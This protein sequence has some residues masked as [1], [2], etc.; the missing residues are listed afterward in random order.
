MSPALVLP[1]PSDR[2]LTAR[3]PDT[4]GGEE[5]SVRHR[6]GQFVRMPGS[7]AI[8]GSPAEIARQAVEMGLLEVDAFDR[9]LVF[10]GLDDTSVLPPRS[11]PF[12]PDDAARVLG[13]LLNKPLTLGNFPR[14][15]AAGHLLREVLQDGEVPRE[16][17]LRRVARFDGVAVLR[18]DGCIAWVL[19]GKTQQRIAPV[20][21]KDG[22]FR[23]HGFELGRFYDGRQT[24]Y[25]QLDARLQPE[26]TPFVT[27]VYSDSDLI[28]RTLDGAE[29][30]F[31]EL[32]LAIGGLFSH[33]PGDA[34][35]AL[36]NLPAGVV[37][38]I[39]NSPEYLERFQYMTEGE[40]IEAVSKLVTNLVATWGTASATTRTL[41]GMVAGAEVTVPALALSSEGALAIRRVAVSAES[42]A[43]V[44]SGGPGAAIIL[45]RASTAAKGSAP[46]G[47]PGKWGPANESMSSR[48]RSY[49]EQI[50]GHSADEAYWVGGVGKNGGGVK[51][52][53]FEKGVLL[54]AKG[55]GYANKFLDNLKPKVWFDKSGAKALVN[56]AQRQLRAARDTSAP[57]RWCIAEEKTA[58]AIKLLFQREK[59]FGI[60]VVHVPPL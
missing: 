14:R 2:K 17:L 16:E 23:A 25:R 49:Q 20:E 18:P 57:I 40:Q 7:A 60:E 36:T 4:A 55:P 24:V 26:H 45:Q 31:V 10:A 12:T 58:D 11:R 22:A 51:F 15:M 39:V 48:A 54:E 27:E 30:A 1:G 8:S 38:L 34:L 6:R 47:G 50:T 52:D 9:L 46:S 43:T 44:L 53:G 3:P 56:Q 35:A 42:V 59:I 33:S 37:A 41:Q 21:W 19:S 13:L 29:E 5:V 32:A 28:G